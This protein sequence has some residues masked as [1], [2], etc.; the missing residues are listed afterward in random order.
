MHAIRSR[1]LQPCGRCVRDSGR[2][3]TGTADVTADAGDP[4]GQAS[5]E[6]ARERELQLS[7]APVVVGDRFDRERRVVTV[8]G[9]RARS[10]SR[11]RATRR[12]A[13]DRQRC[14]RRRPCERRARRSAR[15]DGRTHDALLV[16]ARVPCAGP[17]RRPASARLRACVPGQEPD[18]AQVGIVH[19]ADSITINDG[20]SPARPTRRPRAARPACGSALEGGPV[21]PRRRSVAASRRAPR[22]TRP[23]AVGERLVEGLDVMQARR[24]QNGTELSSRA[25]ADRFEGLLA[26]RRSHSSSWT[27]APPSVTWRPARI[28]HH[29]SRVAQVARELQR[30]STNL[31]PSVFHP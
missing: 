25:G 6:V 11:M 7:V 17:S 23:A 1:S 21:R 19:V 12:R 13:V 20:G 15:T 26:N 27:A 2:P 29:Q 3:A 10:S 16:R 14:T 28:D 18:A 31:P 24:E 22:Q 4:T 30:L 5:A 9:R 8:E